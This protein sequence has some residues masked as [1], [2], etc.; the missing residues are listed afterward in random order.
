MITIIINKIKTLTKNNYKNFLER[1][2]T[3]SLK[4][5][6]NKKG[7]LIRH[8]SYTRTIITS[9]GK[10]SIDILRV[11]CTCCS[12]THA[13]V[14]HLIVPYSSL[15]LDYILAIIRARQHKLHLALASVIPTSY[16]SLDESHMR[17]ILK[18]FNLHWKEVLIAFNISV[19]DDIARISSQCL[20]LFNRQF[21]QIKCVPNI[22]IFCNYS[23]PISISLCFISMWL[24][25]K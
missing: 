17:Y 25:A 19:F 23:E 20:T 7:C 15:S 12:K 9:E 21:M 4:C 18:Q 2:N 22:I 24:L 11:K 10:F 6:C 3:S 1:V 14:P 8:G 16:L 5:S 13:V